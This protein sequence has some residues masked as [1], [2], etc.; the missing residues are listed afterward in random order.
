VVGCGSNQ[1]KLRQILRESSTAKRRRAHLPLANWSLLSPDRRSG[2]S[3]CG[4][5]LIVVAQVQRDI[6]RIGL[7]AFFSRFSKPNT[8]ATAVLVDELNAR[9]F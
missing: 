6:L 1:S 4:R 7:F 3:V 5:R 9:G 2:G 8:G